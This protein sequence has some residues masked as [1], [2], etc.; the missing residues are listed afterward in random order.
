L[1]TEKAKEQGKEALKDKLGDK[2]KGLGGLFGG[3]KP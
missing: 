2:L 3:K 1:A